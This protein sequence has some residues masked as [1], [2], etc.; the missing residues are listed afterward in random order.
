[1]TLLFIT[2]LAILTPV[3]D[4][5]AGRG[6]KFQDL[7][8]EEA[9]RAA[10]KQDKPVFVYLYSDKCGACNFLRMRTL[11]QK[12]VWKYYNNNFISISINRRISDTG[13]ISRELLFNYYPQFLFF[14]QEGRVLANEGGIKE[15]HEF[16][17]MAERV[18]KKH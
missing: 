4:L 8:L 7:T 18:V 9:M 6:I 14:D 10:A 5:A 2:L 12:Q 11:N 13:S 1:M 17:Q 15:P 3:P 16:L